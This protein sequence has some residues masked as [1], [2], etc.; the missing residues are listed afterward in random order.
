MWLIETLLFSDSVKQ[1]PQYTST[2]QQNDR[3]MQ[4]F[5]KQRFRKH[6]SSAKDTNATIREL[7]LLCGLCRNVIRRTVTSNAVGRSLESETVKCG[8]ESR[9]TRAREWLRWRGPAPI[10]NDRPVLSSERMLNKGYDRK[11]SVGKKLLVVSFKG[12]VAKT[13]WLAVNRQP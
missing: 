8:R 13:S 4:L 5:S 9:G 10:V 2:Q 12:L 7:C 11:F 1:R 6:C 3:V